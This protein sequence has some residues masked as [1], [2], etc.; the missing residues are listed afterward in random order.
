[1]S[2][3]IKLGVVGCG[4]IS[5]IYLQNLTR[6]FRNV[7]VVACMDLIRERSEQRAA[8]FGVPTVY[9]PDEFYRDPQIELVVNLTTPQSHTEV[10]N[11]S[12][13]AGKNVYSEKPKGLNKAA[14][15]AVI[16]KAKSKGLIVGGAPETFL[17]GG[18]QTCRKLIDDGWLGDIVGATAFMM[19][20]GHESWHPDP[21]FYYQFGGGP[22]Y[23]MGPYYLTALV[24]MLGPVKKV[25]GATRIS[26]PTRTI[27]SEKKYGNIINV[28]IPTYVTGNLTFAPAPSAR[29]SP[30]STPGTPRCRASRSM[31]P[32][33][34]CSSRTRTLSAG[35]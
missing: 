25:S 29:S 28:E 13:D 2:R 9:E 19:G 5:E 1:M 3:K 34:R 11:L 10:D 24:S 32:A 4:C 7:E 14:A 20:H 23:D 12:I 33:A 15:E 18:L 31:A 16:K 17:G 30:R 6:L 22:M 26:F 35:R 8:Q 27:T 21:E